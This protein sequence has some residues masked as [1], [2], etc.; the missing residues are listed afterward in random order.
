[1]AVRRGRQRKNRA[2]FGRSSA[3]HVRAGR[4]HDIMDDRWETIVD[5][6]RAELTAPGVNPKSP[7]HSDQG[8]LMRAVYQFVLKNTRTKADSHSLERYCEFYVLNANGRRLS[9]K[10]TFEADPFHWVLRALEVKGG[11]WDLTRQDVHRWAKLLLYARKHHV[12]VEFLVG[13]LH[14]CGTRTTIVER[15]HA[16]KFEPWRDAWV[17]SFDVN[18]S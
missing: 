10:P 14:Q 8:R 15:E 11:H 13:F 9:R 6:G 18:S 16:G 2:A 1:M 7:Y 5:A 3:R 17:N 4:D 12:P